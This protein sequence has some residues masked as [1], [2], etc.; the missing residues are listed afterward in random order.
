MVY[1][2]NEILL[3]AKKKLL[4][5]MEQNKMHITKIKKRANLK[6]ARCL[7]IPTA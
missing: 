4:K 5:D 3:S 7:W 6:K 1:P 2:D